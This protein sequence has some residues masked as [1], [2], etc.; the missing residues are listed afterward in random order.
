MNYSNSKGIVKE[1][2]FKE[3]RGT[4]LSFKF[5][6]TFLVCFFTIILSIAIG[7]INYKSRVKEFN[8]GNELS[9]RSLQIY[10]SW[11]SIANEGIQ[12]SMKPSP[13]SI[14]SIGIIDYVGNVFNINAFSPP[15]PSLSKYGRSPILAIFGGLD[16]SFIV[17]T[18][19]S[20][21]A[22][23]YTYDAICGEKESGTLKL[24]LSNSVKRTQIIIGKGIG[25][26]SCLILSFLI[27]FLIGIV[28]L[29]LNGISFGIEHW[30]RLGFIL[31]TFVLFLICVLF[32]GFFISSI[33]SNSNVSF[34]I[35]LFIWVIF[36]VLAPMTSSVIGG[37]LSP[38]PSIQEIQ[39]QKLIYLQEYLEGL[40]KG[41]SQLTE[42]LKSGKITLKEFDIKHR[43]LRKKLM[44]E[45]FIKN[46]KFESF[47][48]RKQDNLN[49]LTIAL[50]IISPSAAMSFAVSD[51]CETSIHYYEFFVRNLRVYQKEFLDYV[52]S[53][54]EKE[55]LI[56]RVFNPEFKTEIDYKEIP[57]FIE[58]EESIAY[59]L[60]R[61]I[62]NL[63][64]LV[65]YSIMFFLLSYFYFIRY[66]PR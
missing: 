60:K 23:L 57:R 5:S 42:E 56:E 13:L 9:L 20:L 58:R 61:S 28:L 59:S 46:E 66:D 38:I 1:I 34:L 35:L 64:V 41:T 54:F 18:I 29:L 30:V 37:L 11:E 53:K 55:S 50:S 31:F 17:R 43:E 2:A 49:K 44:N 63:T 47:I 4:I 10:D 48:Q 32:L 33:T 24:L 62:K 25:L 65:L 16:I 52:F 21:F 7:I 12:I 45:M 15:T 51:L 22:L 39:S 3:F 36:L 27:P 19:L 14:F 6:I 40:K 26:F 8:Y